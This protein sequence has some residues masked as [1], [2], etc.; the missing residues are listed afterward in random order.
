MSFLVRRILCLLL[1]RFEDQ[2]F[3]GLRPPLLKGLYAYG[4]EKL[5]AL[6]QRTIPAIVARG[7]RDVIV[8]SQSGTG[9]SAAYCISILQKLDLHIPECQALVLGPTRELMQALTK[10]MAVMSDFMD[11]TIHCSI[12][13]TSPREDLRALQSGAQIVFGTPG[14]VLDVIQRGALRL[15]HCKIFCLDEADEMLLRGFKDQIYDIFRSLPEKVQCCL[16]S[17]IMPSDVLDVTRHLM[18]DPIKILIKRDELTLENIKQFYIDVGREEWKLDTLCDLCDT[19][20]ITQAIIYCNTRRKVDWL[21]DEMTSR[22]F[23]VSALHGDMDQRDR[24]SVLREYRSGFSRILIRTDGPFG[25]D[26]CL[27]S[28]HLVINYD[29]PTNHENYIHRIGRSRR[30][31]RKGVAFNFLTSNDMS[32]M[33]DIESIYST[34][35][36]EMPLNIADLI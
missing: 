23:T 36:Q 29:L 1:P 17:A 8:Q 15:D 20:T 10:V 2:P 13:G 32:F 12:N 27:N 19:I 3:A 30:F 31:G 18:R 9:K 24:D 5:S 7:N 22:E 28:I 21:T 26:I 6:Q 33:K 25:R 35:V 11:T 14:H 4:F 16:F 34:T